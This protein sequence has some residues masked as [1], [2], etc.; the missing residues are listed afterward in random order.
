ML[1]AAF[2]NE[3]Q[4]DVNADL[5]LLKLSSLSK[6]MD[7][8]LRLEERNLVKF[9]PYGPKASGPNRAWH[10]NRYWVDQ[11]PNYNHQ[12]KNVQPNTHLFNS[13]H[14]GVSDEKNPQD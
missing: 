3:L 2:L 11:W 1:V 14:L 12:P 4:I 10:E 8:T 13:S 9:G 7:M 5:R 6:N